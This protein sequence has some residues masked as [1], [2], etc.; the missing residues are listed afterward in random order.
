MPDNNMGQII[1]MLSTLSEMQSRRKS[2]ELQEAQ[3][4]QSKSQFAQSMG[5]Q[6]KSQQYKQAMDFIDFVTRAPA[7]MV[8]QAADMAKKFLPADKAEIIAQMAVNAP[9]TLQNM[10]Q[11]QQKQAVAANPLNQQQQA[12]TA[13]RLMTGQGQGANAQSALQ[14]IMANGATAQQT[15]QSPAVQ[16]SLVQNMAGYN[17]LQAFLA[18]KVTSNP[19][20]GRSFVAS[21]TGGITESG[22]AQL[23][24]GNREA[25]TG[26]ARTQQEGTQGQMQIAMDLIRA[27]IAQG[28]NAATS[29]NARAVYNKAMT[30]LKDPKASDQI[31]ALAKQQLEQVKTQMG[32]PGG[33]NSDAMLESLLNSLGQYPGGAQGSQYPGQPTPQMIGV[34]GQPPMAPFGQTTTQPQNPLTSFMR[35]QP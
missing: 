14:A 1:Q 13:S 25:A 15:A 20:T 10:V 2:L 12:E 18:N 19:A 7:E 3:M 8:G 5:Y 17:P 11:A 32:V 24:L 35:P 21:Q 34:P 29:A 23:A 33:A 22:A 6:E 26:E 27:Q 9:H 4:E 16:Q 30:I 31:K 28:Q